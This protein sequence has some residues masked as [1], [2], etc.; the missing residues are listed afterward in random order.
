MELDATDWN[1]ISI[2]Q[3]GYENNNTIARKLGLSEGTIRARIKRLREANVMQI[4]ALINPEVLDNKQLALI[5]MRVAESRLL[6]TKAEEVARLPN[7]LSV[8][9]ASGRY[10]LIAEV[11]VDS[12]RGLVRF[13]TE[14]LSGVEGVI[15]SES[16]L[17]LKSYNKFV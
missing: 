8:S 3:A 10:D 6:E 15:S 4:R 13:L 12:N 2:L 7:V 17:M 16:F 1:I 9:I 14:E 5:A 11:L